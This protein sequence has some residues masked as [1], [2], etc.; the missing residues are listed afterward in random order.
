MSS[1]V[2]E[3]AGFGSWCGLTWR[4]SSANDG[5]GSILGENSGNGLGSGIGRGAY[6]RASTYQRKPPLP[7]QPRELV[8]STEVLHRRGQA[9]LVFGDVADRDIAVEAEDP[10]Y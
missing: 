2:V 9:V 4:S 5:P 10:A 6:R 1:P 7:R 8:I 3:P